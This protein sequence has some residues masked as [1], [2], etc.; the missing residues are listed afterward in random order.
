[1]LRGGDLT[2]GRS[3]HETSSCFRNS[4]LIQCFSG[5]NSAQI[6]QLS[7]TNTARFSQLRHALADAE[8]RPPAASERKGNNSRC[9]KNLYLKA[10]ARIWSCLSCVCNIYAVESSLADAEV[11][12]LARDLLLLVEQLIHVPVEK[13][14]SSE[15]ACSGLLAQTGFKN[16]FL[17]PAGGESVSER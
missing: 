10:K 8:V 14:S 5:T 17:A 7:G 15:N 3:S 11:E 2:R 1:M 9:F 16:A 4:R 13:K 12:Q 6:S